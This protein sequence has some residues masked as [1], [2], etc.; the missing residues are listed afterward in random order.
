MD[1]GVDVKSDGTTDDN[2]DNGD[3]TTD[4][5]VYKYGNGDGATD[6]NGN[7]NGATDNDDN[8]DDDGNSDG[9]AVDDEDEDE[10]EDE[11]DDDNLPPRVGKRND[12]CNETKTDEEETVADS[13]AIHTTIKQITGRGMVDGGRRQRQQP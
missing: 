6:N 10:D 2:G 7:G 3:G 9:V 1:N 4:D 11:D 8:D 12:G 13:V 5:D